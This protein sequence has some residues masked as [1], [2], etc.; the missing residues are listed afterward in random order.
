MDVPPLLS[1]FSSG[2]QWTATH[3]PASA[4]RALPRTASYRIMQLRVVCCSCR[5]CQA[6]MRF[7][8]VADGI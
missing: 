7:Q 3:A 2:V 5:C 1:Q 8:P 6:F 4:G